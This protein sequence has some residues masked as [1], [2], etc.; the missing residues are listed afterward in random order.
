MCVLQDNEESKEYENLLKVVKQIKKFLLNKLPNLIN[1]EEP[2]GQPN[3]YN[4]ML[5][6]ESFIIDELIEVID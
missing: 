6:K 5:F 2:Y 1:I 4:Q 3:S